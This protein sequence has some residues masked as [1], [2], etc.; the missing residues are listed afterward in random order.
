MKNLMYIILSSSV[1]ISSLSH[2]D[3]MTLALTIAG[4]KY[5]STDDVRRRTAELR[6]QQDAIRAQVAA[7]KQ[8]LETIKAQ[9]NAAMG[10]LTEHKNIQKKRMNELA[11]SVKFRIGQIED[12]IKSQKALQRHLENKTNQIANLK[13][14]L[15]DFKKSSDE[16]ENGFQIVIE[17]L[18]QDFFN[19]HVSIIDFAKAYAQVRGEFSDS[20]KSELDKIMWQETIGRLE[21][22]RYAYENLRSTLENFIHQVS[23]NRFQDI[24][25]IIV[26]IEE[27]SKAQEIITGTSIDALTEIKDNYLEVKGLLTGKK[28]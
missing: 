9:K 25:Q 14:R 22:R 20:E 23:Q 26:S 11:E 10:A 13:N 3:P 28:S 8:Q 19:A 24:L 7:T 12:R 17:G 27:R 5:A 16:A 15:I 1:L 4:V 2:G 18:D 6:S 21:G